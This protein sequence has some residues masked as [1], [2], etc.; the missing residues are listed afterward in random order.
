MQWLFILK[1][2]KIVRC[3]SKKMVFSIKMDCDKE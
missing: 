1:N 3:F 2:D